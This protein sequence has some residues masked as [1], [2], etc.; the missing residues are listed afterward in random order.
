M[1]DNPKLTHLN[2]RGHARMVDISEKTPTRRRATASGK[3]KMG[4]AT[5]ARLAEPNAKGD[6]LAVARIA[7]IQA[8]KRTSDLIP[9]CHA[10]VLDGVD[11][12]IEPVSDGLRIEA[13]VVC[14]EATGVEMEALTAVSVTA[15]TIY[16][17]LKAID[18]SMIIGPIQ[19]E[20]KSGG[21]S[22]DWRRD[23]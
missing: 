23:A 14:R 6:V 21:R 20:A 15:L 1:A 16:D 12:A 13:T 11:I 18:R 22:G 19:L 9:L 8:T 10:L 7:G 4:S 3:V 17:M 5:L 2:D